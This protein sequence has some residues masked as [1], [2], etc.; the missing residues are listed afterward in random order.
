ME[1]L[2]TPPAEHLALDA[3]T[4][5]P[6]PESGERRFPDGETYV[7][8]PDIDADRVMVV[9]SGQPGPD[10]GLATLYA[11]L[12]GLAG[13]DH[14]VELFF[15]Y[16][17]YSR[18]DAAFF[19]GTVN[20]ARDVLTTVTD[21]YDVEQVHAI[22]PH[23][24]HR[25][26]TGEFPLE[27][28]RSFPLLM[29]DVELDDPVVVGPDR[30]AVERFG[31]PGFEKERRGGAVTVSGDLDVAG[32]DV[33]VFDDIIATGATMAAAHDELVAQDAARVE[34]A[35]VHGAMQ[36][37]VARV[38]DAYDA[39]HLA[40]TVARDAATVGIEPLVRDAANL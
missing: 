5:E 10:H 26:W 38:S 14:E 4:L 9:H 2:C 1:L 22:D 27:I 37:G 24:G 29:D 6:H 28:H 19:P 34:A 3:T 17:P 13:R 35:A 7:Q 18:H 20:R 8:V 40:N 15:T 33:L 32:R 31:V 21:R 30:G 36:E 25:G 39:L 11:T 16:Q 23:Y 12:A